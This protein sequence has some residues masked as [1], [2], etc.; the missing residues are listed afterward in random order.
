MLLLVVHSAGN[1]LDQCP[2]I[3][4]LLFL[5]YLMNQIA[6]PGDMSLRYS[7][8]GREYRAVLMRAIV[9]L[10]GASVDERNR[11]VCRS[12]DGGA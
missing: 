5:E 6:T 12:V 9:A 10:T 11:P 8:R 2:D 7:E 4:D 1:R 3:C